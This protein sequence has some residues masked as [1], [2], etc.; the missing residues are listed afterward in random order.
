VCVVECGAYGVL[1]L[2]ENVVLLY[3]NKIQ[4]EYCKVRHFVTL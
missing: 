2:S 3:I 4:D 1:D